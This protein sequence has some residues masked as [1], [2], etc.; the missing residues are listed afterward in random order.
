MRYGEWNLHAQPLICAHWYKE[1]ACILEPRLLPWPLSGGVQ[2]CG[3]WDVTSLF[4]PSGIKGH[5]RNQDALFQSATFNHIVSQRNFHLVGSAKSRTHN[6]EVHC[7]YF[8]QE[9]ELP[10]FENSCWYS[11]CQMYYTGGA[12]LVQVEQDTTEATSC[13]KGSSMWRIH[14]WTDR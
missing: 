12:Y 1:P 5:I 4:P 9:K 7:S 8:Q 13:P 2:D 11:R 3:M 14:I 10:L 6:E